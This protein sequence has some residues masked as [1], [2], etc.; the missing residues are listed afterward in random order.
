MVA[1]LHSHLIKG[2]G[3]G[4]D[5]D[6]NTAPLRGSPTA[7]AHSQSNLGLAPADIREKMTARAT[8]RVG[9]LLLPGPPTWITMTA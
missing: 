2:L 7:P 6:R 8:K 4:P 1:A 3:F 9:G 5:S